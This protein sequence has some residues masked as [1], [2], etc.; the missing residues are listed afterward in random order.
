MRQFKKQMSAL[1]IKYRLGQLILHQ[2]DKIEIDSKLA[3]YHLFL[4]P[5]N[6]YLQNLGGV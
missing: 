3:T 2:K 4:V 5:G 1:I 6:P